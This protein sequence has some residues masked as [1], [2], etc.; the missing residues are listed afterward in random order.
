MIAHAHRPRGCNPGAPPSTKEWPGH[1]EHKG[2]A[3]SKEAVNLSPKHSTP[4]VWKHPMQL[5]RAIGHTRP[6]R[7]RRQAIRV[8]L[9]VL[10][11]AL[12]VRS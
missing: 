5:A 8:L 12:G 11:D 1:L 10:R 4:A 6:G 9:R 3:E 2:R 7:E